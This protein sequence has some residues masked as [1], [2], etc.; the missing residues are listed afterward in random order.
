MNF[1]DDV[2]VTG[3]TDEEH[4][5]NL[6]A[7]FSRLK[8]AGFRVNLSKC[9]FFQEEI[10]YLGHIICAEGLKKD[11]SKMQAIR[12]APRPQTVQE[13]RAFAGMVNYYGKFIKNLSGLM[14]PIYQ[15][16]KKGQQFVWSD[17]CEKVFCK[18]KE[19]MCSDDILVHYDPSLKLILSCDASQKGIGAVLSCILPD[20]I[21]K[22]ITYI[23]RVLSETE[24][25][26]SVIIKEALATLLV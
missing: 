22:P 11:K 18:A 26:Y 1:L 3:A 12:L 20:G 25:K 2:I 14:E 8:E 9:S 16:L 7:V 17:K 23:S 4:T 21:E 13:V 10:H 5:H 19:L 15:L 6:K 24:Q